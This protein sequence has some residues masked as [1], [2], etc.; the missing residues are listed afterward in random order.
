MTVDI[1]GDEFQLYIK[2]ELIE[3]VIYDLSVK[4]EKEL[5][6]K[7]PVFIVVLNGAFMF[8]ADLMRH[9]EFV[10]EIDFIRMG[11][12]EGRE[13]REKVDTI[14]GL[15]REIEGKNVVIIEDIVDSGNTLKYLYEE[16]VKYKPKKIYSATFLYKPM[17]V[18]RDVEVD[19]WALRIPNDFVLGYGLD[20]NGKGRNLRDIYKFVEK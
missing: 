1:D 7:K 2:H 20:Y 10:C 17:A 5:H 19:W 3:R 8:A 14:L 4:M 12:Y 9:F 16:F 15:N 18:K 6:D 11:S 13:R